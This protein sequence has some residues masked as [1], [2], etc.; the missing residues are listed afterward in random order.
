[1]A[2]KNYR[3]LDVWKVEMD[4]VEAVYRLTSSWPSDERFGL[5]TQ[6]RRAAVSV[7]ANI[8]EGYGRA[9]PREYLHH[10]SYARG[11]LL[12]L[13]TH[14]IVAGR[15]GFMTKTQ[16]Q[17]TWSLCQ[18]VGKMLLAQISVLKRKGADD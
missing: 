15:V 2:L 10:L 17:P 7:P 3:E 12:E 6:S 11:S 8:A 13:E 1:M 18:R 4:L 16:A 14:L 5:T 9:H